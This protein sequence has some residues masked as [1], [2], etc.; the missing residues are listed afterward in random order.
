MDHPGWC[1]ADDFDDPLAEGFKPELAP[2]ET[3][4]WSERPSLP[5]MRP[6][7]VVPLMFV[8]ALTSLSGVSLAGMLGIFEQPVVR[9]SA[10]FLGF[11]LAPFVLGGLIAANAL[12][13]T[14]SW[15]ARRWTLARTI[16]GLTDQRVLIG[17]FDPRDGGLAVCSLIPGMIA[18]T[19]WFE[20]ADGTGDLYFEGLETHSRS[21]A[22][23]FG[24]RRVRKV[25]RLLHETLIDPYPRW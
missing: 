24:I 12:G 20:Y 9:P 18:D 21:A 4:L 15:I 16:Y 23:F 22:G 3:L 10:V 13:R 19:S 14:G 1:D 5:R 25:D 11:C 6:V 17:R 8:V 7:R 2:G